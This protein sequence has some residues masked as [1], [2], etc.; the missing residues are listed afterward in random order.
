MVK[1]TFHNSCPARELANKGDAKPQLLYGTT[2]GRKPGALCT[3][4]TNCCCIPQEL[5]RNPP[6]AIESS[7]FSSYEAETTTFFCKTTQNKTQELWPDLVRITPYIPCNSFTW[8]LFIS[9]YVQLRALL[10]PA[11]HPQAI[12]T[13]ELIQFFLWMKKTICSSNKLMSHFQIK[14]ISVFYWHIRAVEVLFV[15]VIQANPS[16]VINKK[17]LK[18]LNE[19]FISLLGT[20]VPLV[21][22]TIKCCV[23]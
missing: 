16:T 23:K 5:S 14:C 20:A 18:I 10:I 19:W 6:A 7:S 4:L 8:T 3:Q 15:S 12:V 17:L 22:E 11:I 2:L 9:R 13:M 21:I 1:G